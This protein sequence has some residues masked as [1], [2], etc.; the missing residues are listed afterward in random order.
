M[1]G[2]AFRT[3]RDEWLERHVRTSNPYLVI[4]IDAA[5][6]RSCRELFEALITVDDA[7]GLA[8]RPGLLS[9][10]S[11]SMV[12]RWA[13]HLHEVAGRRPP[14][15]SARSSVEVSTEWND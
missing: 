1:L 6:R 4:P 2:Y 5:S 13:F 12:R 15:V 3:Q 11:G 10:G 7:H 9:I 8:V 14:S